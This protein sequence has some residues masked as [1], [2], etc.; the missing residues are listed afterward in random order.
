MA[1]SLNIKEL[2]GVKFN[3]LTLKEETV[4][5]T[6]I[7]GHTHRKAV[8]I[9]DC[10]NSKE[11]QIS[12]VINGITK[13]CGCHSRKM[14]SKRMKEKNTIH[15][16]Y[17]I[18]EYKIWVSMKKRCL[19]KNHKSFINYG[20]RGINVS[21][22]WTESFE[23]F[24]NDMGL[25]PSKNH[26]LERIENDKGYFKDNCIWA[27]KKEQCRNQRSNVL[28]SAFGKTKCLAEWA[29]ILNF[30]WQK[31]FYRIFL[32]KNKY[33]LEEMLKEVSYDTN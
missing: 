32:S 16:L 18:P 1:K 6:T 7:G 27:T 17:S 14:A 10:G 23:S 24:I 11:I 21:R 9:C 25:R 22:E 4:P 20:G 33:S 31:L 19:N 5:H 28:M 12:S 8:F 29:E 15:G 13:S 30:S 2:E 3:L 26:S